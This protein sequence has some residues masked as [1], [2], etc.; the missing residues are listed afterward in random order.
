MREAG[1]APGYFCSGNRWTDRAVSLSPPIKADVLY[2]TA[3]S[4]RPSS[5]LNFE[6]TISA[7]QPSLPSVLTSQIRREEGR[8]PGPLPRCG[9]L[10]E[11]S[12][13]AL[14]ASAGRFQRNQHAEICHARSG[15]EGQLRIGAPS[16]G[17]LGQVL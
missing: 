16:W 12:S 10:A 9:H 3:P 1:P 11:V 4:G 14:P 7:I 17:S 6:E 15:G 5:P 13:Q 8:R 2:C